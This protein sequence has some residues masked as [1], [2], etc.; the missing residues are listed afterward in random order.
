MALALPAELSGLAAAVG[1][2]W[3]EADEDALH[4]A[5]ARWRAVAE[6]LRA[7]AADSAA[8]VGRLLA[9]HPAGDLA[10]FGAA[11]TA[12]PA[13]RF[14]DGVLAA[15]AL[16]ACLTTMAAVVLELKVF[17]VGQLAALAARLAVPTGHPGAALADQAAAATT[18]LAA[19]RRARA[20]AEAVVDDSLVPVLRAAERRL[21]ALPPHRF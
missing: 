10:A 1:L 14:D 3:P 9:A 7:G 2:V 17:A 21:S 18:T 6:A 5:A 20:A 8:Q 15:Q 19:L 12:G 16:A 13:R 11:W 4:V